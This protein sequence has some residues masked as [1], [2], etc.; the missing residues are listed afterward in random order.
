MFTKI[1]K[2]LTIAVVVVSLLFTTSNVLAIEEPSFFVSP[3]TEKLNLDAGDSYSGTVS[4]TNEGNSEFL[5]K[6]YVT[7]YTI[8]ADG[9][10]TFDKKDATTEL[11]EW[12]TFYNSTGG[13]YRTLQAGEKETFSYIIK[14]PH[15]AK[16]GV[17]RAIVFFEQTPD[18]NGEIN[19]VGVPF[20][21]NVNNDNSACA[22]GSFFEDNWILVGIGAV[23]IIVVVLAVSNSRHKRSRRR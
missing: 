21:V 2:T 16:S 23:A 17:Q 4:I 18:S 15:C 14:V 22:I 6:Q 1:I 8:S 20:S 3:V 12:F 10:Q 11:S 9:Y 7:P 19:R 5:Y 13:L